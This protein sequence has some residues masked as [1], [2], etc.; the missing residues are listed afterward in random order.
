ML[1]YKGY[2]GQVVYDDEARL[3]HGEVLQ[4]R[5]TYLRSRR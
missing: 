1:A 4:E 5:V 3:F 2:T